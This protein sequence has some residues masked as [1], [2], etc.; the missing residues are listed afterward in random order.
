[1]V[2]HE[3]LMLI[4]APLLVLGRP[5]PVFLWAFPATWRLA[6]GHASQTRVLSR[7]WS[8]LTRPL[9]AWGLH[10][11]ALWAWHTPRLFEA[12]LVNRTLH[13][14]QHISFLVTA[15][16]FWSALLHARAREAQGAAILYLFTTTVHTGVLGAL[17]TFGA[18]PWYPAY[19]ETAP[20]WGFSALEDQQLGGLIMWVPGSLVYVGV[21]L[22]LLARWI[23]ASDRA[24]P[25]DSSRISLY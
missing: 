13:D 19:V 3:V 10:A 20:Y 16:L 9:T 5:L 7:V 1:M 23:K 22:A 15:L 8:E 17:I 25:A 21:A 11:L 12:A 6:L 14:F 4:A 18:H 2:Q 24:V